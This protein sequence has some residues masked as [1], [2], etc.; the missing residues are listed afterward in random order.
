[1]F[2]MSKAVKW[3]STRPFGGCLTFTAGCR[4]GR[5]VT[6]ITFAATQQPASMCSIYNYNKSQFD[7]EKYSRNIC[8]V[9]KLISM[10]MKNRENSRILLTCSNI[11]LE[12]ETRC[13]RYNKLSRSSIFEGY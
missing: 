2:I 6:K 1:M 3:P 11:A 4:N 13:S 9:H 5:C 7:L 12:S 8:S 10:K